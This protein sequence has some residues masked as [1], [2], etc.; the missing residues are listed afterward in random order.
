[1]VSDAG[2]HGWVCTGGCARVG[3]SQLP[4][5]AGGHL[6]LAPCF[7][8]LTCAVK[9]G[10]GDS[11]YTTEMR[12]LNKSVHPT[13]HTLGRSLNISQQPLSGDGHVYGGRE[14]SLRGNTGQ[15]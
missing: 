6:F 7:L 4:P 14:F 8:H 10:H 1:M 2:M 13:P 3:C 9:I 5:A 12:K 11:I 15:A